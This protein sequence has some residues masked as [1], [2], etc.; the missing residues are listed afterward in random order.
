MVLK[1]NKHDS[2]L[3]NIGKKLKA[4]LIKLQEIKITK[5]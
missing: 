3:L 5:Q 1:T 2:F 4:G